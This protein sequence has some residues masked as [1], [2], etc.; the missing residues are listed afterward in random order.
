VTEAI[1]NGVNGTLV[2]FFDVA[3][4]SAALIDGLA[5]P[6]KYDEM[7]GEARKTALAR[8]DLRSVCLPQMIDFVE[9]FA[10]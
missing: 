10:P 2:D 6:E 4:W 3:A 1:E 9:S 8:Y 5:H 7:R